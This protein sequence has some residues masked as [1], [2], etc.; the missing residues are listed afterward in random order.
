M[1]GEH[2]VPK[3]LHPN[4]PLGNQE[5]Y[6]TVVNTPH[7]F[8]IQLATCEDSLNELSSELSEICDSASSIQNPNIGYACCAKFSE[9]N[10]WYRAEIVSLQETMANVIFVDYGNTDFVPIN[11]LK[12]LN[13]KFLG[14]PPYAISCKL[15]GIVSTCEQWPEV[16]INAFQ[17]MVLDCPL[18]ITFV[19]KDIPAIVNISKDDKDVA[20]SLID[21]E[22]ANVDTCPET[23]EAY[24]DD[25]LTTVEDQLHSLPSDLSYPQRKLSSSKLPVKISYVDS[26]DK[27][28]IMP[29]ELSTELDTVMKTL[30]I[31]YS[32]ETRT[33]DTKASAPDVLEDPSISLPCVAKHSED[34]AWYRAIITDIDG[35]NIYIFFVDY[36]YSEVSSLKNLRPLTPELIKIPPIAIECK[37]YAIQA[38]E[39]KE[40]E[41]IKK[42]EEY[43]IEE[44]VLD[45]E[46][47]QFSE[48][49]EIRLYH[50]CNDLAEMLC[51]N[52]L[53]TE[54]IPPLEAIKDLQL[55]E[56]LSDDM[57]NDL[58]TA[59]VELSEV[60][61]DS[62]DHNSLTTKVIPT[63]IIHPLENIQDVQLVE[64]LNNT[65]KDDLKASYMEYAKVSEDDT[66][67][68]ELHVNVKFLE[69]E[70]D[71][72]VLYA[73][74]SED[75]NE[76]SDF[77]E[78][79]QIAYNETE[80]KVSKV[81]YSGHCVTKSTEDDNWYRAQVIDIDSNNVTVKFIDYGNS[82]IVQ[83]ED[84]RELCAEFASEPPF[85]TKFCLSGYRV[86][87]NHNDEV[88]NLLEEWLYDNDDILFKLYK[89]SCNFLST[90]IIGIV[91]TD[92]DMDFVKSLLDE[93]LILPQYIVNAQL[94]SKFEATIESISEDIFYLLPVQF[95]E[96]RNKFKNCLRELCS[97]KSAY[98]SE[99]DPKSLYAVEIDDCWSRAS[100]TNINNQT[101]CAFV[102]CI[103]NGF[104]TEVEFEK[105]ALL[106]K[107]L[108]HQPLLV[109]QCIITNFEDAPSSIKTKDMK[110]I[111]GQIFLCEIDSSSHLKYPLRIKLFEKD[112]C[113]ALEKTPNCSNVKEEPISEINK[114]EAVPVDLEPTDFEKSSSEVLEN[115]EAIEIIPNEESKEIFEIN[116][117]EDASI[118]LE[119]TNFGDTITPCQQL[120]EDIDNDFNSPSK[121][122]EQ[123]IELSNDSSQEESLKLMSN[124]PDLLDAE[125]DLVTKE[126]CKTYKDNSNLES[127]ESFLDNF[128]QDVN[129]KEQS[130]AL[131]DIKV[132]NHEVKLDELENLSKSCSIEDN[133]WDERPECDIKQISEQ[134]EIENCEMQ[135]TGKEI[136]TEEETSCQMNDSDTN[137]DNF[138]ICS[139]HEIT[140]GTFEV[141]SSENEAKAPDVD[142]TSDKDFETSNNDSDLTDLLTDNFTYTSHQQLSGKVDVYVSDMIVSDGQIIL[143][144][145]PYDLHLKL[146]STFNETFQSMYAKKESGLKDASV[147]DLCAVYS[148]DRWFRG[149]ILSVDS[150][151][152]KLLLIDYGIT[153][154]VDKSSAVDL[155]PIHKKIPPFAIQCTLASIYCSPEKS[156]DTKN[157][158]ST[159]LE[160]VQGTGKDVSIEIIKTGD[161][162]QVN[163]FL[164]GN[165]ILFELLSQKLVIQVLSEPNMS[166]GKYSA[167]TSHISISPG[168][169]Q[170][171]VN[172]VNDLENLR[173]LQDS[174]NCS[175][176]S[177]TEKTT[178]VESGV[179]S[180]LHKDTWHR[181]TVKS[182][183]D[184]LQ[185]FLVDS[186]ETI[187]LDSDLYPLHPEHCMQPPFA[188]PCQFPGSIHSTD[189]I[190]SDIKNIFTLDD[191]II[192]VDV[193]S[194]S[195][196]LSAKIM[197][198]VLLEKIKSL[199]NSGQ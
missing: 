193:D 13:E 171:Y 100:I 4:V 99:V 11:S 14:I 34:E 93:H 145:I 162:Q 124:D 80:Q 186:G 172:L 197:D 147:S 152:L 126:L 110:N 19:S 63:E 128:D 73:I 135:V 164:V 9:D 195:H 54:V 170:L 104:E 111:V 45:M 119:T 17:D 116:S 178:V 161:P 82:E 165:N 158:L 143:T 149:K 58:K 10:N 61:N 22:L 25:H 108:W 191:F 84:I 83:L 68:K 163:L 7:D 2:S 156:E 136:C 18:G 66:S 47:F 125:S 89:Y 190:L 112:S 21:M 153:K 92:L 85:I 154:I 157:F 138:E 181:G 115:S 140:K 155:D 139:E 6:V 146:V 167:K 30:E 27:F 148:D 56:N 35:D 120:T 187:S 24:A 168:K 188:I 51:Q 44:M 117:T 33:N 26:Y 3:F 12:Y 132:D 20:Q 50:N 15:N 29:L 177:N 127:D 150:D 77:Q 159:L 71:I 59:S 90:C 196:S 36:G 134:F 41:I 28:Y 189:E 106:P 16:A 52:G 57:K 69:I 72:I 182:S 107:S 42:L 102:K 98:V 5:G 86:K 78:R 37:M 175:Y 76:L 96:E 49:Y 151:K 32:S 31:L 173:D 192:Y 183:D 198:E 131:Q 133:E 94:D 8:F 194:E 166:S 122:S 160:N 43:F 142:F 67:K 60:S 123:D 121:N 113:L 144:V 38:N 185:F 75:D 95:V 88:Q 176:P 114:S 179:Y 65:V 130:E 169:F 101:K 105:L 87:E 53:T 46:V 55:V 141:D 180:I 129:E 74:P 199:T 39:G 79:L 48:P 23:E 81:N 174:M 70:N 109:H 118:D 91:T 40:P 64:N 62:S 137:I 97:N 103:D 1:K 184:R